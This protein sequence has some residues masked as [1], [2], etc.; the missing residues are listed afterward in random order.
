MDGCLARGRRARAM[1]AACQAG[2]CSLSAMPLVGLIEIVLGFGLVLAVLWDVFQTVVLPRPTPT[3]WRLAK[4][5]TRY[6]YRFWRWRAL[7]LSDSNGRERWLGIF[8]PSIVL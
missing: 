4:N 1:R 3:R 7:R 5:L 6:S 2:R 8:G